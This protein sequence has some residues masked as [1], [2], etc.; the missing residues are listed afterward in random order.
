MEG[1]RDR[2]K[3]NERVWRTGETENDRKWDKLEREIEKSEGERVMLHFV[4]VLERERCTQRDR[5]V[6][7]GQQPLVSQSISPECR[8]DWWIDG[9]IEWLIDWLITECRADWWMDRITNELTDQLV[10]WLIREVTDGWMD[11]LTNWLTDCRV[12]S[13]LVDGQNY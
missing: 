10:D 2:N 13:W 7:Q 11:L 9:L 3:M 1:G 12:Q 8:A 6:R 5:D 4:Q